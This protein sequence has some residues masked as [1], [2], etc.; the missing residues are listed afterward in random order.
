MSALRR[1]KRTAEEQ[2]RAEFLA[3][4][5]FFAQFQHPIEAVARAANCDDP[6]IKISFE[7]ALSGL[8]RIELREIFREPA[9]CSEM[10]VHVDQTGQHSLAGGVD[11]PGVPT[12]CGG[13]TSLINLVKPSRAHEH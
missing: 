8:G 13:D 9:A 11:W 10:H 5:E 7:R 3:R 1:K 4:A 6:A 12:F 2:F